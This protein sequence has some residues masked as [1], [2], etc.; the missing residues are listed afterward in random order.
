MGDASLLEVDNC[1]SVCTRKFCAWSAWADWTECS[2][3]CGS[4]KRYKTRTLGLVVEK[5]P[6]VVKKW[7]DE[8]SIEDQIHELYRKQHA[9]EARQNG[10]RLIAFSLG[11]VAFLALIA[12]GRMKQRS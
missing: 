6:P 4:G 5:T 1:T 7:M 2:T 10:E 12:A 8:R 9:L 3:T 11:A